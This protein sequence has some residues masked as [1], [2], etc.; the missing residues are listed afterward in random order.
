MDKTLRIRIPSEVRRYVMERDR[1]QC[2]HCGAGSEQ[3]ELTVDHIIPLA[4]G[5]ANDLSNLQVL[6][7]RCNSTKRHGFDPKRDRRLI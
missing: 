3:A 4:Q 5:G 2:N 7:R 1:H 6:C